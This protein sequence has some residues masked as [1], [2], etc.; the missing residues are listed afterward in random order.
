MIKVKLI[1]CLKKKVLLVDNLPHTFK[2]AVVGEHVVL[3]Q[4]DSDYK[5]KKRKILRGDNKGFYRI[6]EP[7]AWEYLF[8]LKHIT[9]DQCEGLVEIYE[10]LSYWE[11]AYDVMYKNYNDIT[12]LSSPKESFLSA[13]ESEGVLF[14]NSLGYPTDTE[15]EGKEWRDEV[16]KQDIEAYNQVE[17]RVFSPNTL[18]FIEH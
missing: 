13:L 10:E 5:S 11:D 16:I 4:N 1:K 7:G 2:V 3:A 18:I 14:K 6:E 15:Y 12:A 8:T 17:Q 9:E